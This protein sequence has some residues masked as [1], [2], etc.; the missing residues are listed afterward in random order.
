MDVKRLELLRELAER[1]SVTQVAYATGRTPSAVSQQL[2][3]LEREAGLPLMEPAGRGIALTAAGRALAQ[4]ATEIAIAI[5]R[6]ES[7]WREYAEQPAG[8]VTLTTFPTG[9]AMLLPNVLNRLSD[10]PGLR[11][12]CSDQEPAQPDFADL[13]SDFDIVLADTPTGSRSWRDRGLKVVPLMSELLDVALPEGHRLA[14]KRKVTPHDLIGERWIG[15]PVDFPNDRILQD[16]AAITGEPVDV[17][18]RLMDNRII[19]ALVAAGLGL[20]ILPRYTTRERENGLI[21]R[22]LAELRSRRDIAVLMRPDRAE[23]PS[24]Q[25]VVDTLRDEAQRLEASHQAAK[26]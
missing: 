20:A 8:D 9:G 2:K 3:V 23:R 12:I 25:L 11:L 13:T 24:V 5:E 4:T 6:A 7:A 15:S 16:I 14:A 19:E 21:T 26:G 18:Q 1:G 22:P 10:M 17:E